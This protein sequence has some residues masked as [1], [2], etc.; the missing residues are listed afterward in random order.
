MRS[1]SVV[2]A[3]ESFPEYVAVQ[4]YSRC[5]GRI[6]VSLPARQRRRAMKP[7]I[8]AAKVMGMAIAGAH[9]QP[10]PTGQPSDEE[11]QEFRDI[12]LEA[13]AATR[14]GLQILK[15]AGLGRSAD[16]AAAVELL[17]R[18]ETGLRGRPLPGTVH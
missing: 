2:Y 1:E 17:E 6:L 3:W 12:G 18:V 10:S 5:L 8:H 14:E 9:A 11:R 15:D 7:M 16:M 13:V 4:Q